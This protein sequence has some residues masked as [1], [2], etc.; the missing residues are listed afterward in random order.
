MLSVITSLNAQSVLEKWEGVY[1][2]QMVIGFT[3]R[4][5]D[6]VDVKFELLPIDSDSISVWSY[7]MTYN[8]KNYGEII[9]DY[10][11]QR[12]GDSETDFILD[13]KDGILIGMSL[14]NDCFYDM[15]EVMDQLYATTL[16]KVDDGIE[17]DLFTASK[18]MKMVTNSEEDDA[19]DSYEVTSYKATQHQTVMLKRVTHD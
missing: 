6:S 19:G 13:E 15:F 4:P 3:E 1:A 7:V 12:A 11:I 14:M 2:G 5:N 16:R 8:S 18:K 9:K 17:F 10:K